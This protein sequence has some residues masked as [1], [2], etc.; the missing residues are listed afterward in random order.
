TPIGSVTAVPNPAADRAAAYGLEGQIIDG[1][2]VTVV[3][4]T[5]SRAA[6]RARAGE[7]PSL[8]EARTYR[9]FGHS[10]TDPAKYRPEEEVKQWL[11]RDPL[12]VARERL[13]GLGVAAADID[14]ADAR[15]EQ[16]VTAAVQAAKAAPD[17]DPAEAL[18]DVWADG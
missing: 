15:A 18:T 8:I 4:E 14:A 11:A 2:D 17:A 6:A 9:H 7:G 16:L 10:R 5:V 13:V 1:N 3:Y 12:T